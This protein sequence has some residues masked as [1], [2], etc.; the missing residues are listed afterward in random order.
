MLGILHLQGRRILEDGYFD[1]VSH[2]NPKV[3]KERSQVGHILQTPITSYQKM[4]LTPVAAPTYA[5][6]RRMYNFLSKAAL[7]AVHD[8]RFCRLN[9][10]AVSPP[11][12]TFASQI[13]SKDLMHLS[14]I[15]IFLKK[16]KR[17]PSLLSDQPVPV[18]RSWPQLLP[19]LSTAVSAFQIL[20]GFGLRVGAVC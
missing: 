3:R 8:Y 18:P 9:Q 20:M 6:R 15:N 4:N 11:I 5:R 7:G 13:C 19:S 12:A 14:Y 17:N 16:G 2:H 10:P 1:M